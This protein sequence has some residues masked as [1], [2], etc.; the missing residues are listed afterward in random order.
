MS[1]HIWLREKELKDLGYK[2]VHTYN[3]PVI[4]VNGMAMKAQLCY[5]RNEQELK[6]ELDPQYPVLIWSKAHPDPRPGSKYAIRIF[7]P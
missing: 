5:F 3:D 2:E 4:L 6:N 7:K 1:E